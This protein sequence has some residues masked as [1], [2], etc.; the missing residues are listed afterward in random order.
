M[1]GS[2]AV[3]SQV[4][5]RRFRGIG[6]VLEGPNQRGEFRIG[7]GMISVWLPADELNA[8]G[9]KQVDQGPAKRKRKN[10]NPSA[11][12]D[13]H[14]RTVSIDLHGK[15]VAAALEILET[16]VDR[17]LLNETGRIEVIHGLGSG[18]VQRAVHERL[19]ALPHRVHFK[20]DEKNPG[21]TWVF[22]D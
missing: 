14:S 1:K 10:R 17:A 12:R 15:T 3:G 7:V 18:A 13:A 2:Y 19:R 20:L 4:E 8:L 21:V 22:L 6:V 16:A 11:G 5:S 9:E